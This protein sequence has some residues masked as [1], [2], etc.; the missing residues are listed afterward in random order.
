MACPSLKMAIRNTLARFQKSLRN[1]LG[2]ALGKKNVILV[3]NHKA[4]GLHARAGIK[5]RTVARSRVEHIHRARYVK[6]AVGVKATNKLQSLIVK[7]ALYLE[8]SLERRI[9][10]SALLGRS[11]HKIL[12][13]RTLELLLQKLARQVRN[14]RK[15]PRTCKADC[16]SLAVTFE[17]IVAQIPLRIVR[18]G[19]AP[20]NIKRESLRIERSRCGDKASL[21]HFIRAACDPVHHLH[22][23]IAAAYESGEFLDAKLLKKH[24][25]DIH[26]IGKGVARKGRAVWL[27]SGGINGHRS[28][29]PAAAAENVGANY[30]VAIRI[31]RPA[32]PHH[33]L[34]PAAWLILA[35]ADTRH[36]RIACQSVTDE[37]HIVIAHGSTT[38]LIRDF[39]FFNNGA[40]LELVSA[41]REIKHELL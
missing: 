6:V 7:I 9:A 20:H 37:N 23:A 26:R 27:A 1:I 8:I 25:I 32:R 19:S 33:S 14:M 30:V 22:S 34:P 4:L 41:L 40:C 31:N 24:A 2:L 28:R 15:L 16:R 35:R 12:L 39:D 18:D 13:K 36:M 38:L 17:I 29:S 21:L 5:K 10:L 11:V 3:R